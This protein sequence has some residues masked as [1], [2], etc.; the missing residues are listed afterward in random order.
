MK[1]A[2]ALGLEDLIPEGWADSGEK[3]YVEEDEMMEESEEKSD[4]LL[5]SLEEFN[6]LLEAE[7]KTTETD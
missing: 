5:A 6:S 2:R 7:T 4:D 1:R 3:S